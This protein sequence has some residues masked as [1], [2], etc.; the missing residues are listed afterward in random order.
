MREDILLD[1][2][3]DLLEEDN[4]WVEG[5]SE[6]VDVQLILLANKGENREF[7]FI[8]FGANKR[9]KGKFDKVK[10]V[11]EMEI[12]L[13]RDGFVKPKITLGNTIVDFKIEV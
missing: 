13:E 3:F 12:E 6:D 5:E 8:G 2:N 11:R 10:F 7:P 4:E 9:L 1:E